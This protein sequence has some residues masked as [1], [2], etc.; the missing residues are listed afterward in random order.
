MN[1]ITNGTTAQKFVQSLENGA[2]AGDKYSCGFTRLA[3]G[4][5][6][7]CEIYIFII[8]LFTTINISPKVA[9]V[10]SK[11]CQIL[12]NPKNVAKLV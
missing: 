11:L 9:K 3:C 8:W 6:T 10:L 5:E 12:K 1:L 2:K 4:S 7:R